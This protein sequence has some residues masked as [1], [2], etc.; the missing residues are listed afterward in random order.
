MKEKKLDDLIHMMHAFLTYAEK[1]SIKMNELEGLKMSMIEGK[2]RILEMEKLI[3]QLKTDP[4]RNGSGNQ[5]RS[6]TNCEVAL[7]FYYLFNEL[8]LNFSNSDKT[9]WS[10]FIQ[11][12][13][14]R[15]FH[16]IR[17]ELNFDFDRK[18]TKAYM[19]NVAAHFEPLFPEIAKT[20]LN[21][22]E[23]PL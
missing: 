10:R 20:I 17:R 18:K 8:N 4:S 21:D 2:N 11:P 19:R 1:L 14:G 3:G 13:T 9:E 6:M 12:I 22:Y 5:K 7:T 23:P 16:C 15:S